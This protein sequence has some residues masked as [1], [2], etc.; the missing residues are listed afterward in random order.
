MYCAMLRYIVEK[1][2]DMFN[3]IELTPRHISTDFEKAAINVFEEVFPSAVVTGCHF[4]LGQLVMRK[5]NELGLKTIYTSNQEFALHARMLYGLAYV[6]AA[7]VPT[8]LEI[9]RATM[10]AVRQP[11]VQYFDSTYVNGPV[12]RSAGTRTNHV[13]HRPPMF[14]PAMWNVAELFEHDLPT[15][16]NHVEAWH[17]RLQTLIAI[18]HPSFYA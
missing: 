14:H 12:A 16:N 10:P 18:D 2:A 7:D 4:H 6:P 9:I 1:A 17:R 3:N 11:L 13:V 15:T 5:V 8:A